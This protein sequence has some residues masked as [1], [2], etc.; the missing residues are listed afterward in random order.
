MLPR[1]VPA[2]KRERAPQTPPPAAVKATWE[3]LLGDAAERGLPMLQRDAVDELAALIAAEGIDD[4]RLA[5]LLELT[6]SL[7]WPPEGDQASAFAAV[8]RAIG[9]RR[10]IAAL[11]EPGG[12][13]L[14]AVRLLMESRR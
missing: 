14:G 1:S 4:A 6:S 5:A 7:V 9:R 13:R 12:G 2:P 11:D 3:D 8:A 10:L